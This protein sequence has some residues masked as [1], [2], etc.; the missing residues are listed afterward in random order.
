MNN[1]ACPSPCARY[2]GQVLS[3]NRFTS[4]KLIRSPSF[5]FQKCGMYWHLIFQPIS[6][7]FI[8]WDSPRNICITKFVLVFILA[9]TGLY[10]QILVCSG[11]Y[12][13]VLA[14]TGFVVGEALLKRTETLYSTVRRLFWLY[15]YSC[16]LCVWAAFVINSEHLDDVLNWIDLLSNDFIKWMVV[17][18]WDG[19][20]VSSEDCAV[21]DAGL[22][23]FETM[24]FALL[25]TFVAKPFFLH[26]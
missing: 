17:T 20:V 25:H 2:N 9:D 15:L 21:R 10:W 1:E 5:T 26:S 13:F 24:W 14:D 12:W 19:F 6:C 11:R 23:C 8:M 22:S 16:R 18:S 3:C 4:N 7:L